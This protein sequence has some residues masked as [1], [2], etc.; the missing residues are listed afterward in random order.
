MR[1]VPKLAMALL[2]GVFVVVAAFTAFRVSREIRAYDEDVRRDQRIVGVTA[3]AA[4][5]K[6]RT[7]EQAIELAQRV[8]ASRENITITFVSLADAPDPGV[9]PLVDFASRQPLARGEWVQVVERV[10]DADHL[11]TYVGAP[12]VD[13]VRGAIQLAQSLAPRAAYISSGLWNVFASSV[14]MLLV[15]AVIV[16]IIGAKMVGQ[17]VSELMT[18]AR[19]IGEGH[20]EAVGPVV[21]KDEFGELARALRSMSAALAA[22]G[23]RMRDETEARIRALEQLRHA[24]RLATLGQLA[25]VLAH[26]IGT[27][28]NVIAG[29]S[30]MIATGR[31]RGPAASESAAAIGTQCERMTNIVRRILDYARRRP[32]R[33]VQIDAT[34][35]MK[36]VGDLLTGLAQQRRV[37]LSFQTHEGDL[38]LHADPDQ[39]RQALTNLVLNALQASAQDQEVRVTA[40]LGTHPSDLASPE[41][42]VVF[43]V[44]DQGQGIA[45]EDRTHIFE[46]FFTTKPAGEGTGLGLSVVRDIAQEHGGTIEV[47]SRMNQGSAFKLYLPRESG[48]VG[49]SPDR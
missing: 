14:A 10:D 31:L 28:L 16:S 40:E 35:I 22:A 19:R 38:R 3:G 4:L 27:P 11:I 25:S 23:Q 32:P 49:A 39:L 1:L 24:E 26:E 44:E 37:K 47:S 29:H 34:E 33:R 41:R 12:V 17:P 43:S 15:C 18:A 9:Q 6:T 45:E 2:A 8:N 5:A 20:F 13:D 42:R 7:R 36:Q 48:N 30:K 46:P 21:R